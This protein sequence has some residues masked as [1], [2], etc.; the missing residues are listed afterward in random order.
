MRLTR[1]I[2]IATCVGVLAILPSASAWAA[3]ETNAIEAEIG[4]GARDTIVLQIL[5]A[6][7]V[8]REIEHLASGVTCWVYHPN[9]KAFTLLPAR[10]PGDRGATYP[11]SLNLPSTV[12]ASQRQRV[13]AR[14]NYLPAAGEWKGRVVSDAKGALRPALRRGMQ[15]MPPP[16]RASVADV[17]PKPTQAGTESKRVPSELQDYIAGLAKELLSNALAKIVGEAPALGVVWLVES[18]EE[19]AKNLMALGL[20]RLVGA[21]ASAGVSVFFDSTATVSQ[22]E[23]MA[24]LWKSQQATREKELRAWRATEA[25]KDA[26]AARDARARDSQRSPPEPR[27]RPMASWPSGGFEPKAHEPT[28][29]EPK[30]PEPDLPPEN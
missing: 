23:E 8:E 6:P 12:G 5:V 21:A 19:L 10:Q 13:D 29:P 28:A 1:S 18:P 16:I 22:Q 7:A 24:A 30:V 14:A 4:P 26:A 11:L 20:A 2:G 17:S 27:D 25:R 3:T 9:E 15:G